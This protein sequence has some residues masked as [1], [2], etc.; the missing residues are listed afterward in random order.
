MYCGVMVAS[1]VVVFN[2]SISKFP[3]LAKIKWL[4]TL[5]LVHI[6]DIIRATTPQADQLPKTYCKIDNSDK[7]RRC[8]IKM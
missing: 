3:G 1:E 6:R 5:S 2:G 7:F 8:R 4:K